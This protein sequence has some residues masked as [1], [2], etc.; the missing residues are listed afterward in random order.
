MVDF[1]LQLVYLNV[2]RRIQDVP[3]SSHL[4]LCL[5][6]SDVLQLIRLWETGRQYLVV[7]FDCRA[8]ATK[9]L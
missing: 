2:K 6:T 5:R 8:T 1:V 4:N 7:K 3:S 9:D